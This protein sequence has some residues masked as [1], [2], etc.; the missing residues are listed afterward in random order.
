MNKLAPLIVTILLLCGGILWFLA[1]GSLN[2]FIKS[3]I[4]INGQKATQQT[5]KVN[6]VDIQLTNGSGAIQ[7]LTLANPAHYKYPQAFS[8]SNIKLDINLASL[9]NEPIVIDAIIIEKPEVFVEV[10][11]DGKINIKEIIDA[12][13]QNMPTNSD[14]Q[15]NREN[16]Q[17]PKL[18]VDKIVL[19]GVSLSLDLSDLG[20]KEHKLTLP[21]INLSSV[22]GAQGLP[23]SQ[24]GVEVTKKILSAI[25]KSAKKVQQ[26]QIKDT[27]KDKAKKKLTD[28]FNKIG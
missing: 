23:A 20:N 4:E 28:L 7:G 25:L 13:E 21:D 9:N 12:I 16:T 14:K 11:K 15:A 3:Q 27:I 24:L 18:S 26:E 5:V 2:E 17:E 19:A 10:K 8:L 1:S 6:N 22:G